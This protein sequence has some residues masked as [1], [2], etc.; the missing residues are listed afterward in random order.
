MKFTSN[1]EK[2]FGKYAVK[3]LSLVL[4]I[5][6]A[7][8]YLI[9]FTNP[10]MLN[11]LYLNPYEIIF[12]GQIWRLVTWLIVPPSGFDFFTLLM[13]YF[14]YSLG[15]TLERTWGTYRYNVYIFSGVLFRSE[16]RRV[17]KEC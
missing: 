15:T 13:L 3:N 7:C 1:F 2:K 11:Y 9:Q 8:G 12:R 16:E 10:Y 5:C 6:Y 17:G 14:Y 4:I